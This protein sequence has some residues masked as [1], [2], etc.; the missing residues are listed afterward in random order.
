MASGIY[1]IRN[2]ADGNVYVGS[3]VDIR[4]RWCQH[5]SDLRR[6]RHHALRLQRAWDKHGESSFDFEVAEEV[7]DRL[8]LLAREQCWIWRTDCT[9]PVLG[10]NVC[11]EAGSARGISWTPEQRARQSIAGKR[12]GISDACR[13][14]QRITMTSGLAREMQAKT[15]AARKAAGTY[16]HSSETRQKLLHVVRRKLDSQSL[17]AINQRLAAGERQTILAAEYG[18][19][20]NTISK[21]KNGRH[22]GAL[23]VAD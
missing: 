3:A 7:E 18:V 21:I 16:A 6:G 4:K 5:L 14:A 9:N 19:H 11:S 2:R 22:L 13:E 1:V 17:I 20:V 10:Y 12:I 8:F 15:V 23:N